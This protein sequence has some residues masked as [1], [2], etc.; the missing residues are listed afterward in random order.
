MVRGK[1]S[2]IC[3]ATRSI[4]NSVGQSRPKPDLISRMITPLFNN[5]CALLRLAF[6]SG[7]T[8]LEIKSGY[9]LDWPTELKMLRVAKQIEDNLPLT[10]YRTFLGAHT[11]PPEFQGKPD[12]YL[13]LVCNEMIPRVA[14]EKL[15][16]AVDVFCEKIAFNIEQTKRVFEAAKAHGLAI[17]CL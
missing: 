3:F 6:K 15:D 8:T 13:D 16:D 17:K 7:L 10:I 9:G 14:K 4:F 12:D 5:A 11:I 1:L 2:S